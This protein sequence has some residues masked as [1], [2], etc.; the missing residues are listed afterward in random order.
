VRALPCGPCNRL[1]GLAQEDPTILRRPRTTWSAFAAR[2]D[3]AGSRPSASRCDCRFSN[4]VTT[5]VTTCTPS[6]ASDDSISPHENDG[7]EPADASHTPQ[8]LLRAWS[9]ITGWRFE[10]SS[11][12]R[13]SPANAGFSRQWAAI[14]PRCRGNGRANIAPSAR[15]HVRKPPG[16]GAMRRSADYAQEHRH[17]DKPDQV[18]S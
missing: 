13:G 1:L 8:I 3:I 12:H 17:R 2:S 14:A 6:H 5:P 11:A 10:S 16:A 9:G 18:G 15:P 4:A 7:V